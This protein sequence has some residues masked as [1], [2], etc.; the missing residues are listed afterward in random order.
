[1]RDQ[2]EVADWAFARAMHRALLDRAWKLDGYAWP[3]D[4]CRERWGV[5][6]AP[7]RRRLLVL[8]ALELLPEAE[9][10]EAFAALMRLGEPRAAILAPAIREHS[11][12]WRDWVDRGR[13]GTVAELRAAVLTARGLQVPVT[14]RPILDYLLQRVPPSSRQEI[15]ETLE[16]GRRVLGDVKPFGLVLAALAEARLAWAR[17]EP[18]HAE[19]RQHLGPRRTDPGMLEVGAPHAA[20]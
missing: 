13:H 18:R 3:R 15:L 19:P 5:E 8:R 7:L 6:W 4:W 2:A 17:R 1:M 20:R 10:R 11:A 14:T 16:L 12:Q 9:Q